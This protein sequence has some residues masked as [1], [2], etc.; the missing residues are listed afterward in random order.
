MCDIWQANASKFELTE[1]LLERHLDEFRRLHVKRVVLSGG[2]ALLHRNLWSFCRLLKSIGVSITLLSTGLLLKHH[3]TDIVRWTDEVIVSLDGSSMVHDEIRN[4]PRAYER[5]EIGVRAIHELAPDFP[6]SSRTVVQRRNFRVLGPLID[7][8]HDIGLNKVSFLPV[9]VSTEAFN[10]PNRWDLERASDTALSLVEAR[11]FAG[12]VEDLIV[13]HVHDFASGFIAEAPAKFRR[14]PR[15]FL[16]LNGAGDF[17]ET[18]CNAPW[19]S[20]VV[21]ATGDVRPCFFHPAQ[22]NLNE[23]GL[24]EILNSPAA[25]EFRH[26]L[27]V[28]HNEICRSCVCTLS[29][30]A[31]SAV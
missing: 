15:Y 25:I 13:S 18:V 1:E 6:V 24:L 27:D 16:A 11:E 8:G 21:E 4:T 20:S 3:A 23:R 29:L 10:R 9:D 12:L 5:L 2:E 7:S 26:G 19:V 31:T 28:R 22:G 17:P 14:I 30:G